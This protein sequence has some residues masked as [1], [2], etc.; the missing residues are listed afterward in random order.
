LEFNQSEQRKPIIKFS[1]N[2]ASIV[3]VPIQSQF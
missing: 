3:Q 1:L 2:F